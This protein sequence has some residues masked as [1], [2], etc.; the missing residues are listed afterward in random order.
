M[1]KLV[2]LIVDD[3][4]ES[5][6]DS[7]S[8]VSEPAIE[9]NWIAFKR[10]EDEFIVPDGKDNEYL[11]KLFIGGQAEDELLKEGWEIES[12]EPVGKDEFALAP[13]KPNEPSDD[14]S[15]LYRI[16]YKYG[17][18]YGI[19]Q[20]PIIDTTREYCRT[21]LRK[22]FVWRKEELMRLNANSDGEDGGFGGNPMIWRGGYNCRHQ[23]WK[24]VYKN[25]GDIINKAS[26]NK[27]KVTDAEGRSL[28]LTPDW[29]QG[30]TINQKT[31]DAVAKGTAAPNTAKNMGLSKNFHFDDEQRVVV[32]PAMIPDLPILRLDEKGQEY[33]VY[34]KEDTIKKI[35]E[36]YMQN[37]FIDNNDI[38]HSGRVAAD[39]FVME[40]WIKESD[41]DKSETF[42]FKELPIGT[43]FVKMKINNE[44][45][46][47]AIK[48]KE[49]N[50]FSVAGWFLSKEIEMSK[51][52]MFIRQLIE[53]LKSV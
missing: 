6:I 50:G 46:W 18:K 28:N 42:G 15:P 38:D 12:I 11:D 30:D 8:L 41:I 9:V 34:F 29:Q 16:R 4:D 26:V 7:I 10:V 32:G 47:K 13:T 45:V 40:T 3:T 51:E 25:T 24:V 17:L 22:N 49:L 23:W 48:N 31:K 44:D 35:A 21:L 36:K 43:W 19:K 52:E 5:G 14:D 1:K 37:K 39:V 53:L 2:E 27:Q 20:E 33:F